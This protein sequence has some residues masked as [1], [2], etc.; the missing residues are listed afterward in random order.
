MLIL[1]IFFIHD[2]IVF[3]YRIQKYSDLRF[4]DMS[5]LFL[6]VRIFSLQELCAKSSGGTLCF[7]ILVVDLLNQ[8]LL[9]ILI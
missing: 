2:H 7:A 5:C 3:N 6:E 9:K 1:A 8:C 4:G